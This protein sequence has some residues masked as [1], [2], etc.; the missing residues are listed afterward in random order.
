MLPSISCEPLRNTNVSYSIA[1]LFSNTLDFNTPPYFLPNLSEKLFLGKFLLSPPNTF[2]PQSML[3]Y[4]VSP[5]SSTC[6]FFVISL[7]GLAFNALKSLSLIVKESTGN[8]CF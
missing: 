2:I 1:S 7:L 3:K 6:A 4:S 5:N 8:V